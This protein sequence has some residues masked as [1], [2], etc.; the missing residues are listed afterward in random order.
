MA[1]I[2]NPLKISVDSLFLLAV[3]FTLSV[4]SYLWAAFASQFSF[5]TGEEYNDNVFFS[6]T[7]EHDFIT[8]FIPSLTLLYAPEGQVT[9]TLNVNVSPSYQLYARNSDLNNFDNTAANGSYTYQYSPQLNFN[10]SDTFQHQGKTRTT[11]LATLSKFQT[12]PTSPPPVGGIMAP[13]LYQ[14]LNNF[15]SGGT[16]L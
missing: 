2:R 4:P 6:K 7:R 8:F 9:P 16:Q 13:P 10:L 15:T 12:G 3:L 1:C 5:S 11:G 14:N